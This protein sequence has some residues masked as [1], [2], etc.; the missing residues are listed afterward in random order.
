MLVATSISYQ[1][2]INAY[3]YMNGGL[4]NRLCDQAKHRK[5]VGADNPGHEFVKLSLSQ[6]I[7][8]FVKGIFLGAAFWS[9][10]C[11]VA[12]SEAFKQSFTGSCSAPAEAILLGNIKTIADVQLRRKELGL[13]VKELEYTSHSRLANEA[14]LEMTKLIPDARKCYKELDSLKYKFTNSH[15]DLAAQARQ[16][17]AAVKQ[18]FDQQA[19]PTIEA[20]LNEIQAMPWSKQ[21]AEAAA[22]L[23]WHINANDHPDL[24]DKIKFAAYGFGLDSNLVNAYKARVCANG[25]S[26]MGKILGAAALSVASFNLLNPLFGEPLIKPMS[27]PIQRLY[28]IHS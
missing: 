19:R 25:T 6:R 13:F 1:T 10:K 26:D 15:P 11:Q 9:S 7:V 12:A 21:R 23:I 24:Q 2:S 20:R 27:N 18:R 28:S 22:D 3:A 4:T 8:S 17:A 16:E 5:E 14:E